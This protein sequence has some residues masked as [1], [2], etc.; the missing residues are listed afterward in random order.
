M[1]WR[2]TDHDSQGTPISAG[3]RV[4]FNRCGDVVPGIVLDVH[5]RHIKI[6]SVTASGGYPEGH[7]SRVKNSR[8]VLVLNDESPRSVIEGFVDDNAGI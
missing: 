7:I 2:R 1:S 3:L 5:P 4:A 6:K 8:G